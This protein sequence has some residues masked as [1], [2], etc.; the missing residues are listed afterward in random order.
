M[1]DIILYHGS[2]GGIEEP[3]RP[4]SRELCDFGRGF[5]MGENELQTQSLVIGDAFP[6]FYKLELQLSKIPEDRILKFGADRSWLDFI[7]YNR[8]KYNALDGTFFT[9]ELQRLRNS[10]DII[11]GPIA[12]DDYQKVMYDFTHNRCSD[13]V[14]LAAFAANDYKNQY[15]AITDKG[16]DAIKIIAEHVPSKDEIEYI[17][18]LKAASRDKHYSVYEEAFTS[19]RREG[20]LLKEIIAEKLSKERGMQN[21]FG[22]RSNS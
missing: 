5:Y 20:L 7:L 16:C 14:A 19:H 17:T 11:I 9:Q 4:I 15:V 8:K 10:A 18:N 13:A 12:D 2:R 22:T 6:V 1:D 21:D 3:I